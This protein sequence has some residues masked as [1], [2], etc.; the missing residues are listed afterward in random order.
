MGTNDKGRLSKEEIERMERRGGVQG[1][2]EG[3]G[4]RLQPHHHQDVPGSWRCTRRHARHG[5][6]G[7]NARR[8]WWS[9]STPWC[10]FWIRPHHRGGRLNFFFLLRESFR[11]QTGFCYLLKYWPCG[12]EKSE[13]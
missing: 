10:W 5:R 9:R 11:R 7:R 12:S 13:N 4:G 8:S 2:T 1:Q 3:G 6:N